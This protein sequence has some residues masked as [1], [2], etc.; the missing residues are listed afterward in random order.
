MGWRAWIAPRS[1]DERIARQEELVSILSLAAAGVSAIYLLALL[2]VLVIPPGNVHWASVVGG[3]LAVGLSALAYGLCHRGHVHTAAILIV[4]GAAVVGFYST[5]VRGTITVAAV[6]LV[7]PVVFAGVAI[8]GRAGAITAA[9]VFALYLGLTF[10][11]QQPWGPQPVADL[12]P[13]TGLVLTLC[14]LSL[15]AMVTWQTMNTLDRLL[16]RSHKRQQSLQA[17]ADEKDAL[18]GELQAREEAQ[19][20]L[21]EMV[22]ELG[23]PV[24]PL[25]R[26]VIAMP[27][28]GLVDSERAQGIMASLLQGVQHNRARVA[29]LD[30]T[31]V[32]VVDTAVAGTLLRAAQGIRLLGAEAVLTGIRPEVAQTMV[33]LGVDLSGVT[34]R[35]TLEEGLAYALEV[36][37]QEGSE[38]K[39]WAG[40]P[41]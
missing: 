36:Q 12:S 21:A 17:L 16:K 23:S 24:I 25:A 10:L 3:M 33:G 11:Q 13:L 7:L 14:S 41:A 2:I 39:G 31:G 8:S 6:L 35:A 29:I 1:T 32:P 40:R 9:I 30:I 18:L 15:L 34:T 26:G 5:Y 38:G 4:V 27:L 19:R 28:I 20:R 37:K 22:H